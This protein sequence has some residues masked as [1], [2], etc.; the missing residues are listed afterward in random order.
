MP[1]KYGRIRR[2]LYN[3]RKT[4]RERRRHYGKNNQNDRKWKIIEEYAFQCGFCTPGIIMALKGLLLKNPTPTRAE[5]EEALSGN[6]CRCI[7]Q[8]HVFA[9]AEAVVKDNR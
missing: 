6:Q 4:I 7:S 2:Q 3:K 9:T 1:Q 5:I 8:Y